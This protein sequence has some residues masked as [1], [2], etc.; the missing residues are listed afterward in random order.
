MATGRLFFKKVPSLKL[1]ATFPASIL[2]ETASNMS[3]NDQ[4]SVILSKNLVSGEENLNL[5]LLL[6]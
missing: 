3:W 1:P 5:I 2:E 4:V 6:L